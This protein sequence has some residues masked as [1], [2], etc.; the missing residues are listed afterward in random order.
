MG[1]R[2]RVAARNWA[3]GTGSEVC[4]AQTGHEALSL[5]ARRPTKRWMIILEHL[6]L[7]MPATTLVSTARDMLGTRAQIFGLVPGL[8]PH[9]VQALLRAGADRCV[10]D[11]GPILHPSMQRTREVATL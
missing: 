6:V 2:P 5:L 7:D 3:A 8:S 11:T 10:E 4:V 1:I 9:T